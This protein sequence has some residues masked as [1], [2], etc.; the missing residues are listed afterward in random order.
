MRPTGGPRR[1]RRPRRSA[2]VGET[3]G[4]LGQLGV[5]PTMTGSPSPSRSA[6]RCPRGDQDRKRHVAQEA[7]V[8]VDHGHAVDV[9]AGR[10]RPAGP[11]RRRP[12]V[13]AG[14]PGC[15]V[16]KPPAPS[17]SY[18]SRRASCRRWRVHVARARCARPPRGR[19]GRRPPRRAPCGPAGRPPCR[20]PSRAQEASSSGSISSRASAAFSGSRVASSSWRRAARGPRAGRPARR[21]A[22]AGSPPLEAR[23][24]TLGWTFWPKGWMAAQS[25]T[26]SGVGRPRQRFGPRRRSRVCALTSTPT[27]RT[28][29]VTG[30]RY[31]SAARMT[32]TPSMSTSWW[33]ST[34]VGQHDLVGG[35]RS[36]ADRPGPSATTTRSWLTWSTWSMPTKAGRRPTARPGR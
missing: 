16:M 20:A 4:H 9:R 8:G 15:V 34:S 32:C 22:A 19:A 30:A 14:G 10:V 35:G 1:R 17:S 25:I 18:P 5:Q 27:R 21:D 28:C 29:P 6:T 11:Q 2:G 13:G 36:P 3:L 26:R 12:F 23:S 31:R 33:S 7:P 24:R